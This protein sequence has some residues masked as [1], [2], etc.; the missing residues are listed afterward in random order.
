MTLRLLLGLLF[1]ASSA[2]AKDKPLNVIVVDICSARSD[3]FGLYGY[4]KDTTPGL[5]KLATETV[6][7][8][9]AIAQSSWCLP[10]YSTL[11]TGLRP[12]SHGQYASVPFK[13]MPPFVDSLAERMK[14]AGFE[15]ASFS[16]GIYFLRPWK[17]DRGFDTYVNLFSTAD[18]KPGSFA[19]TAPKILEWVDQQRGKPFFLYTAVDDLHAPYQSTD[20]ERYDRGYDGI[21]H[22]TDTAHVKFFRLFNGE[23]VKDA[24][25]LP[26]KL[27]EFKSDPKHLRHLIAHYDAAL[28]SVDALL[29]RFVADLKKRGLWETSLVVVTAD[30]GELLGEKGLLGH[31]EGLYDPVLRVP[32]LVHDPRYPARS[33]TRMSQLVE[34]IDLT[35]TILDAAGV[36]YGV[37]LQGKSLAPLLQ[38]PT[39]EHRRYSYASSKRNLASISDMNLDERV[40]RTKKWKLH[41]YLYKDRYELYDLETDPGETKDVLAQHPDVALELSFEMMRQAELSR[42]HAA[43]PASG[44]DPAAPARI[45]APSLGD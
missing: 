40:L 43:G 21:V 9:R 2:G 18:A 29:E 34:R 19:E 33:G 38:D 3:H 10:N 15:T 31:T 28:H 1:A 12:E 11:F 45:V 44:K 22:D 41:W 4:P 25:E 13:P 14:K 26:G 6:V 23:K 27:K 20:P 39:R 32:L 5:D 8:D 36:P 35:P 37:E 7:F 24:G 16:G 17:L 42:S 30:H